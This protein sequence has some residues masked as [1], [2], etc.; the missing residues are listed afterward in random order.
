MGAIDTILDSYRPTGE[1]AFG[2]IDRLFSTLSKSDISLVERLAAENGITLPSKDSQYRYWIVEILR[3]GASLDHEISRKTGLINKAPPSHVH[4]MQRIDMDVG[5]LY[6][7]NL[8]D[9]VVNSVGRRVEGRVLDFGCSSGRVAR[10]MRA[11]Y[12]TLELYACDPEAGTVEWAKNAFP[13]IEFSTS[14]F[15]PPTKYQCSFF[16]L[17]YAISIWSH[18]DEPS[19]MEWFE[20]MSRVIKPGGLLYWTTHGRQSLA[21]WQTLN[22]RPR[23]QL[24]YLASRLVVDGFVFER[25]YESDWGAD[26][27]RWGMTYI[28]PEWVLT[29]LL[30]KWRVLQYRPGYESWNQDVYLMERV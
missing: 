6:H 12:K 25:A 21:H 13:G 15:T 24:Q 1:K 8:I 2:P 23:G 3:I 10:V 27:S 4:S 9:E 7:P 14:P 17:V 20:E 19:A 26:V 11:A 29:K 28:A 16:D 22:T 5:S 18:F 30:G